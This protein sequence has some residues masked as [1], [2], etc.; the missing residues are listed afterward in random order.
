[1]IWL[2]DGVLCVALL[3]LGSSGVERYSRSKSTTSGTSCRR[4]AGKRW[5]VVDNF[6]GECIWVALVLHSQQR[7]ISAFAVFAWRLLST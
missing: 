7:Y 3:G 6:I 4:L 2:I 5:P 1:M